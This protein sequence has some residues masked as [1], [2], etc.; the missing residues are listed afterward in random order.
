[1]AKAETNYRKTTLPLNRSEKKVIHPLTQAIS[2]LGKVNNYHHPKIY[3]LESI[4]AKA[5]GGVHDYFR[6]MQRS[7]MPPPS[8]QT[9][10]ERHYQERYAEL[11][12]ETPGL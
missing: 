2:S 1:V 10:W 8:F 7:V 4:R 6:D 11:S 5:S 3:E 9:L 12:K